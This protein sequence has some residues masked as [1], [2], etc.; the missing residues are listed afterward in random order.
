MGNLGAVHQWLF[1]QFGPVGQARRHGLKPGTI[2][3]GAAARF[4]RHSLRLAALM[5]DGEQMI[6]DVVLTVWMVCERKLVTCD[7]VNGIGGTM[8]C[9]RLNTGCLQPVFCERLANPVGLITPWILIELVVC[10]RAIILAALMGMLL[11]V[12]RVLERIIALHEAGGSQL[13]AQ[14]KAGA[15]HAFDSP[16]SHGVIFQARLIR[17]FRHDL[18]VI[19]EVQAMLT[20]GPIGEVVPDAFF[21]GDAI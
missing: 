9:G 21:C 2:C 5:G 7:Q 17:Q 20:I 8:A 6:L 12:R 13:F 16:A 11:V 10:T 1:A 14:H 4:L 3:G 15:R 19:N 18:R